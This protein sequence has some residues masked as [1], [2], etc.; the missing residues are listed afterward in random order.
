MRWLIS[1]LLALLVV[2]QLFSQEQPAFEKKT[3]KDPN[4]NVYWP[5]SLPVYVQLSSLPDAKDA[6]MLTN[7]KEDHMKDF[8]HPMKWDGHGI[9]FIRHI[10]NENT[11]LRDNE[12][13]FPVYVDGISPVTSLTL[14]DAPKFSSE[15]LFF[16]KGLSGALQ[17]TD[18]MSGVSGT[19][20]SINGVPYEISAAPAKF[21]E[22]KEYSIKY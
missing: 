18:E 13:S 17:S 9:H 21:L 20:Q 4:G 1:P 16:G 2:A 22:E 19:Y 3:V 11:K 14:L 5:L 8:A 7:V 12:I 10:D 6:V 15:K